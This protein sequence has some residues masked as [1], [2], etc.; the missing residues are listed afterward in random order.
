MVFRGYEP[1]Q[2]L[3]GR[4]AQEPA[5]LGEPKFEALEIARVG[6]NGIRGKL[7]LLFEMAQKSSEFG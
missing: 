1:L 3:R 6:R 5:R 4:C 2:V 7:P